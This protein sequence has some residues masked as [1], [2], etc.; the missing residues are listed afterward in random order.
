MLIITPFPNTG[1]HQYPHVR[2]ITDFLEL[3]YD[4]DIFIY[5][6]RGL[7]IHKK[8]PQLN[9]FKYGLSAL[10]K[11]SNF[12]YQFF[13]LRR[14]SRKYEI[15][16]SIDNFIFINAVFAGFKNPYLWSH[17][18]IT[19]DNHLFNRKIY[20]ILNYLLVYCLKTRPNLI[21]QDKKR[22]NLFKETYEIT[23][24][25]RVFELPL[26]L[27]PVIIEKKIEYKT[28]QLL[29]IGGIN[30]GRSQSH[31]LV[32]YFNE[33]NIEYS[34]KFHGYIDY[35]IFENGLMQKDIEISEI[36]LKPNEMYTVIQKCQIGLISYKIE[37]LNFYNIRFASNQ[38]VEFLRN[39]KPVIVLGNSDLNSFVCENSIGIFVSNKCEYER[40]IV[41]IMEHYQTYSI[42]A[43]NCYNKYFNIENYSTSL[44]SYLNNE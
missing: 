30:G 14:L 34:L 31:L 17:D 18:F 10:K 29:Q 35:R 21:I 8:P 39:G 32:K 25:L 43:V 6:E 20:K 4:C 26:V 5:E 1:P 22:L 36:F 38:L 28:P 12:I 42:N 13:E 7:E 9:F 44:L 3:H 27:P 23:Y 2:Y 19:K 11:N 41:H 16:I 24:E 15:V 40:A 33:R 37:D